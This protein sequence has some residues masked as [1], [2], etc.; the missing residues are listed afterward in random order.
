MAGAGLDVSA[1]GQLGLDINELPALSNLAGADLVGVS[2]ADDSHRDKRAS[3]AALA[4][5]LAGT[6]LTADS[7]GVLSASGGGGGGTTVTANPGTAAANDDLFSVTIGT[8][9]YNTADEAARAGVDAL[10]DLVGYSGR[11]ELHARPPLPVEELTGNHRTQVR[12]LGYVDGLL[13]GFTSEAAGGS[14]NGTDLLNSRDPEDGG[15][16]GLTPETVPETLN[17]FLNGTTLY[18]QNFAGGGSET[19][20]DTTTIRTGVPYALSTYPDEPGKLY[21][22]IDAGDVYVEE[23]DYNA[24]GTITH[25]ET[26][27]TITPAILNTFGTFGGY[28]DETD[29]VSDNGGSGG[30]A[31]GITDLYVAGDFA[32]FLITYAEDSTT[33]DNFNYIARFARTDSA[34]TA[35]AT[36]TD[37]DMIETGIRSNANQNSLVALAT[38]GGILTDLFVSRASNPIID[39][40]TN[41]RLGD[42]EDLANRPDELT[43]ANVEDAT[44][45]IFGLVSGERLEEHTLD[46]VPDVPIYFDGNMHGNPFDPNDP[47]GPNVVEFESDSHLNIQ[48]HT[49]A[50]T[51]NSATQEIKGDIYLSGDRTFHISSVDVSSG[52]VLNRTYHVY[53]AFVDTANSDQVEAVYPSST[54]Y[55]APSNG[56]SGVFTHQYT[57]GSV[58]IEIPPN[59]NF[60]LGLAPTN[61]QGSTVIRSGAQAGDSPT[62]SNA[63]NSD[64]ITYVSPATRSGFAL[65]VNNTLTR[66]SNGF[67]LGNWKIYYHTTLGGILSQAEIEVRNAGVVVDVDNANDAVDGIN[68]NGGLEAVRDTAEPN[69]PIVRIED[70]GVSTDKMAADSVTNAKLADD[71]V[72][73][74]NL[75]ADLTERI[76]PDPGT[77][78]SG[79]VCARNTAGT[80]YE[81]VTPSGGGVAVAWR[82]MPWMWRI[83]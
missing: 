28:E 69:I 17:F 36:V 41:S 77:G 72:A 42:Y 70:L 5:H 48:Y 80:A 47:L 25:A 66:P 35:P 40:F 21:M 83:P 8:T 53:L 7:D 63:D 57:W 26:V 61:N 60:Y 74:A 75:D 46:A 27:A 20:F 38:D 78:S 62:E 71:A 68:F 22:L 34:I 55:L 18:A 19:S 30:D 82:L 67:V 45:E 44:S 3:L 49:D 6:N 11:Q 50:S 65:H 16:V 33:G 12:A 29:A 14:V 51:T 81:L 43:T 24:G 58:G 59:T 64:D 13:Y 2:D 31:S 15:A 79:Q 39:H 76:C 52:Y 23:L 37:V 9:D 1:T 54:R 73:L 4:A 10:E 32:W 56:R